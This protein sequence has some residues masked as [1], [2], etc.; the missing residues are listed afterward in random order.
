MALQLIQPSGR[1]FSFSFLL[2]SLPLH[3]DT[4]LSRQW[5]LLPP[6]PPN[7]PAPP[8]EIKFVLIFKTFLCGETRKKGKTLSFVCFF[9]F[10]SSMARHE[11]L[12]TKL[13]FHSLC[14]FE[15]ESLSWATDRRAE[16]GWWR[17]KKERDREKDGRKEVEVERGRDRGKGRLGKQPI[18]LALPPAA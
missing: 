9:V 14:P 2:S 4:L 3:W 6:S 15:K 13:S 17:E 1:G 16:E 8:E 7:F 18:A 12:W 11:L 10:F 5:N